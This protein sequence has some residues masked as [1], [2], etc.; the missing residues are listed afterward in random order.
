[1]FPLYDESRT[2]GKIPWVTIIFILLNVTLFFIS[3]SDIENYIENFGFFPILFLQGKA[4]F[5]LFSSMF[6]HGGL[7]H[8]FGNMWFLW[9]FGDN[10]ENRLGKIR[11]SIFY[12]LSGIGGSLLYSFT[13][14]DK[15]IPV[16]GASGAI[17]G[18]LA[19]YLI[20]FPRNNIRALVLTLWF[21][22]IISIPA[23]IY[24]GIWFLYQFL[25]MGTYS[26]IAYWAH[27]G[28]FLAGLILIQLLKKGRVT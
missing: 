20:L 3:L 15:S 10:L 7:S 13:A 27:I 2:P 6:L 16:I 25:F 21:W 8:L 17:S 23:L 5:S 24:I 11:F 9:I 14:V 12:L 26:F 18:V 22:R 19:G 1:M 28:G 4:F